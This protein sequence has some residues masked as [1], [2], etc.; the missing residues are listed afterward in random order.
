MGAFVLALHGLYFFV[1][2]PVGPRPFPPFWEAR[3]AGLQTVFAWLPALLAVL[4]PAL[5]MGVWAEERRSG[6]EELLLA[7]PLS[8]A[9]AV[10]GKFLAVWIQLAVLLV[11]AIAPL[12]LVVDGLGPL[13]RGVALGGLAGAILLGGACVALGQL[14]SALTRDQ[15]VAFVLGTLVLGALWLAGFAIGSATPGVAAFLAL[16]SPTAH[17]LDSAALGLF[18]LGDVL[19]LL[20]A[21]AA[22]LYGTWLAVEARRAQ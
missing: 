18:D 10:L 8:S 16:V 5:S 19:Y 2:F 20:L 13:D 17:Y 1:G 7:W 15:L 4:A 6:T 11:I 12:A 3:V 14:V 21:S 22:A 9:S